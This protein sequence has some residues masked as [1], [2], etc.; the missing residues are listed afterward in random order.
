MERMLIRLAKLTRTIGIAGAAA[1]AA[2][3][4]AFLSKSENREKL[5]TQ[6][7]KLVGKENENDDDDYIEKLGSPGAVGATEDAKMVD[8]GALTSVQYYNKL[9]EEEVEEEK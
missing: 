3:G 9:Q 4:V 1:G 2:V 6:L 5:K 8:E 7:E